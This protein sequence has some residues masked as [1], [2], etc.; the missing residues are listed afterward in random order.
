MTISIGGAFPSPYQYAEFLEQEGC[1]ERIISFMP[2]RRLKSKFHITLP[3]ER[4][5]ALP[6][7][8]ALYY[9][10]SRFPL[11]RPQAD[12]WVSGLFESAVQKRLGA[13]DVFNGWSGMALLSMRRAKAQGAVT[14]LC[15]GSAHIAYQ[16]KILETEYAKFG[17]K[18]M[19]THPHIVEKGVRE[20]AE[21]DHIIVPS[22][23]V[24]R[25][26]VAEGIEAAKISV[27][28][29]SLTR[30][31]LTSPKPDSVF[32]IIAVGGLTFRKGIQYLLEAVSQ[33][34][35][36]NSELLLVGGSQDEFSPILKK[37]V[38]HYKLAGYVS[39]DKLGQLYSQSSVFVLPS[40]EDGWGHVTLEAMS[41][42]LPAIVS[43]NAGSADALQD[44][45]TGFVV[46]A[47]NAQAIAAKL[48]LLYKH[49]ELRQAMGLQA[50]VSVQQ[51]S[52]DEYGRRIKNI[53][54]TLLHNRK[55]VCSNA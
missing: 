4:L 11:T 6:W 12:V 3:D 44:G 49:P 42:G 23:F 5:V 16:K 14:V 26:L 54:D 2:R 34:R 28:P 37:Y 20:Y 30:Q 27:V 51:Y 35:L 7:I 17:L 24:R 50:Q 19:V 41:C 8:G 10:L 48:E 43:A 46:P 9:G 1:L 45:G 13:C 39:T 25:T 15:T 33:L 32:R 29:H 31:F 18:R 21:A 52:P 38:G 47:C 36:P 22:T 40:V 55:P 53:F